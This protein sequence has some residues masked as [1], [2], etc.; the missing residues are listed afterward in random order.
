MQPEQPKEPNEPKSPGGGPGEPAR[1]PKPRQD[2]DT[3]LEFWER[4]RLTRTIATLAVSLSLW[5]NFLFPGRGPLNSL[6]QGSALGL[7][8]VIPLTIVIAG[9]I[10]GL[11]S[12]TRF[13]NI[14]DM[15]LIVF[16][17]F[18]SLVGIFSNLYWSYGTTNNFTVTEHLTRLD[19]VYFTVGT[20]TTAGTGNISALSQTA[21]GLQT[22]QMV[23]GI[24]FIVFAVTLVVAE[25]SSRMQ[26]KRDRQNN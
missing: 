13:G 4:G 16:F 15:A 10:W 5:V 11:I 12:I 21:R 20:L 3:Y 22:L 25:I 18:S 17:G 19:A 2:R 7:Y 1:S 26:R 9:I 6:I 8:I 23:L 14:F 24:G